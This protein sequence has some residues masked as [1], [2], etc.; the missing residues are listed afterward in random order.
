MFYQKIKKGVFIARPNRFIAHVLIDNQEETVH[1]KNTGRC[2]ELLIPGA[3]IYL[4]ECDNPSRKTKFDLIA[5]EKGNKLINMDAQA[6]N[7]CYY[8]WVKKQHQEVPGFILKPEVTFGNS[9]FDCMTQCNDIIKYTEIKGVTL[10]ENGHAKFPDAP[11]ERG[12]KHINELIMAK[13]A[14]YEASIVFVIQMEDV[15]CFSPNMVTHAR[16]GQAL[17]EAQQA[18]VEIEAYSCKVAPDSLFLHKPIPVILNPDKIPH[19]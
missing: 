9:R 17:K 4:E 18:G 5:V 16:F 6:P 3:T 7:K 1:V 13:Q 11:T 8:E 14:G 19:L 12:L 2:K 10:E 15:H